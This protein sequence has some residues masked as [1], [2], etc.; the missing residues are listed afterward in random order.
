MLFLCFAIA[1]LMDGIMERKR[2]G[3]RLVVYGFTGY[4]AALYALFYPELIGLY[5]PTWYS[6]YFLRWF[7]SW[8]L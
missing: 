8:P 3:C 7:P 1:Y 6:T 4:A 2:R 5:V